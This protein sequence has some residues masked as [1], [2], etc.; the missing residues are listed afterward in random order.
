MY[1]RALQGK[2]KTL[3]RNHTSTLNTV[4][5]LGNLYADQGKLAEAEEMYQRMLFISNLPQ[6]LQNR[7]ADLQRKVI[8]LKNAAFELEEQLTTDRRGRSMRE[9]LRRFARK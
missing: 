6:P 3:G 7:A 8:A 4:N 2:E 5:N 9:V 1:Q